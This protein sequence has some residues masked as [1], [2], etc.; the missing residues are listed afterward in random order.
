MMQED[1]NQMKR[2]CDLIAADMERDAAEFDGKRLNGA[3]VAELTG[4][5]QAAIAALATITGRLALDYR[6]RR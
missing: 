1:L 6:S 5:M 4:N 3:T 2:V